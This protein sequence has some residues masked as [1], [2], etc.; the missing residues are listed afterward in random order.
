MVRETL[1]VALGPRRYRV[2]RPWGELPAGAKVTD[3]AIDGAG[4]VA[5][6]TRTDAYTDAPADPVIL[7]DAEDGRRI[8]AF[9][10]EHLADAHMIASDARGRLWV[11]D[12][13]AH[14]CMAFDAEGRVV[15]R[16]GTRHGP[17]EPFNHP[18]DIAFAPDGRIVV[19]DG[20]AGGRIHVFGADLALLHSFG[21]VGVGPGEFLTAHG[22]WV[23]RDGR[24]LV[25]DRE[26]SRVQVFTSDGTFLK[27]WPAF[28]RPSDIWEDADGRLYISDGV[29]TLSCYG[30]DGTLL[31]RCRPVLNGAHGLWGAP[32]GT[33]YLAEG[34]PSRITRLVPTS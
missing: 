3:V 2:E 25:A 8:G 28:H 24:I 32:D 14:Q 21:R 11:V 17:G 9:G 4:R 5:V 19:A 30:A 27:V 31:G 20:Y 1:L 13:D 12:R 29:P 33:L 7:L 6:L 34:N 18:S 23:M 26:N 16:L 15:A 22:V 10:R